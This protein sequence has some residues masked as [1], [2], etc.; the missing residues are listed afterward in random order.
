MCCILGANRTYGYTSF[1][2]SV[3]SSHASIGPTR[4]RSRALRDARWMVRIA[5]LTL[6]YSPDWIALCD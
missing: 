3:F 6:S 2:A 4:R 5:Y 1:L